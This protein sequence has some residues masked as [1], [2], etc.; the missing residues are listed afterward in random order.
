MEYVH[1]ELKEQNV[2][3]G[4]VFFVTLRD[5][6]NVKPVEAQAQKKKP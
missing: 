1:Q 4:F 2:E 3:A 6:R 5:S